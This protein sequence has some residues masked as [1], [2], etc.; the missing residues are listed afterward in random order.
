MVFHYSFNY[1]FIT[2]KHFLVVSCE[3]TIETII[4]E[5]F[6][7][8]TIDEMSQLSNVERIWLNQCLDRFRF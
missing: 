5:T 2:I 8:E 3:E 1:G 6:G 4:D 7:D